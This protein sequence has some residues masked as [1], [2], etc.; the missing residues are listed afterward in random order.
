MVK[1]GM[2]LTTKVFLHDGCSV[3]PTKCCDPVRHYNGQTVRLVGY[4][5]RED[6]LDLVRV[7][8]SN[9]DFFDAF[10]DELS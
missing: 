8:A 7:K 5:V 4:T 1:D 2:S 10:P 3:P 9:G 6:G